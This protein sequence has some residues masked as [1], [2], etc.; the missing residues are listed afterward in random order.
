MTT[1]AITPQSR[2]ALAAKDR[3]LP[4]R[5]TGRL[6]RAITE[7]VWSGASRKQAAA[8]AGMTDHSLRQALRRPHVIAHYRRELGIL[9]ESGRARAFHRLEELGQQDENKA[10]A[11][12]ACQIVLGE[13]DDDRASGPGRA[14]IPGFV[15]VIKDAPPAPASL[16]D[17][18]PSPEIDE[19]ARPDHARRR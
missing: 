18:T 10:A 16:I 15:I 2:Q 8:T 4:N 6:L 12:K 14:L 13:G 19:P 11:V 9:R 3:S 7:M 1:D 17:I 5:V